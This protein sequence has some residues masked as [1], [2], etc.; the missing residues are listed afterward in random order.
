MLTKNLPGLVSSLIVA[1]V[2][3]LGGCASQEMKSMDDSMHKDMKGSMEK[4]MM[5]S[6]DEGMTD[7]MDAMDKSKDDS[8]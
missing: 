1:A 5:K 8:M 3:A 6:T 4:P 2:L 7:K